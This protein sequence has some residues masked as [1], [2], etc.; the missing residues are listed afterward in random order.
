MGKK[1]VLK[2]SFFNKVYIPYLKKTKPINVF[3][4]GRASGKT[5]FIIQK[6]VIYLYQNPGKNVTVVMKEY[7]H[8]W[9]KVIQDIIKVID[10]LGL[11]EYVTVKK[12]PYKIIIQKTGQK[13]SVFSFKGGDDAEKMKGI[14]GQDVIWFE[15][16]N[17]ISPSVYKALTGSLRD[18]GRDNVVYV[19]FNPES[20]DSW[21]KKYF[22]DVSGDIQRPVLD[23]KGNEV[24]NSKGEQIFEKAT[25]TKGGLDVESILTVKTTYR[26]NEWGGTE[27]GRKAKAKFI[28]DVIEPLKTSDPA[29]YEVWS[30]GNW[31]TTG[32][33]IYTNYRIQEFDYA[34]MLKENPKL[35]RTYGLDHGYDPDPNAFVASLIDKENKKIY[36]YD[37][38]IGY[39]ETPD[40]LAKILINRGYKSAYIYADSQE[41]KT[42]ELLRKYGIRNIK[43]ADK[44]PNSIMPGI[45][46]VKQ[47]EVII[48]PDCTHF[49]KEMKNY[50]FEMNANE[51]STGKPLDKNNHLMD[52][53]RYSMQEVE[54]VKNMKVRSG[55]DFGL[56]F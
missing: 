34:Q 56:P 22:F 12:S 24:F 41:K 33:R 31:G 48:H 13:A 32:K 40:V 11:G 5:L 30:K 6:L 25:V 7:G 35:V 1:I 17:N 14:S 39:R 23:S 49:H 19:S 20:E 54:T 15:E 43:N 18:S 10:M 9:D 4:G 50:Q 3:Y 52:A 47:Y 45:K 27:A 2:K 53:F 44:G 38:Y 51:E 42:N 28:R 55:R 16:A 36:V 26:D 37:E 29:V 21:L 46:Y 8:M